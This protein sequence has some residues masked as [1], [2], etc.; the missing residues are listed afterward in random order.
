MEEIVLNP[1]CSEA[2]CRIRTDNLTEDEKIALRAKIDKL[3]NGDE[4]K[5]EAG[6]QSD[7]SV[8]EETVFG[9]PCIKIDGDLPYNGSEELDGALEE[10]P[11]FSKLKMETEDR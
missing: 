2:V 11:F 4:D 1:N 6:W 5:D 9:I 8:Y 10:L 3:V 7:T